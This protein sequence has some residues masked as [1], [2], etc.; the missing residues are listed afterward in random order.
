[1]V[2]RL[3]LVRHAKTQ[4]QET[5]LLDAERRLTLAGLFSI[6]ARFPLS[7]LLLPDDSPHIEVWSSPAL[8][9]RETAEVVA[10][11]LDVPVIE[12]KESLYDGDVDGFLAMVSQAHGTV[13]AVGHNPFME[14]LYGRLSGN[15][16]DMKPGA[17]ASFRFPFAHGGASVADARLEW[18]VQGPDVALWQTI[19]DVENGL[20]AA[21]A[22]IDRCNAA[23]LDNMDDQESLHQYRVSLEIAHALLEFVKPYCKRKP[24]KRAVR[25]IEGLLHRTNHLRDFDSLLELLDSN[26]QEVM[27]L[28]DA[29][30]IER[31]EF[32]EKF[33]SVDTQRIIDRVTGLLREIPWRT[34]VLEKGL[35]AHVLATRLSEKQGE[36]ETQL[37]QV[38]Y[39]S[40]RAVYRVRQKGRALQFVTRE[41]LACLPDDAAAIGMRAEVVQT[42]LGEL[43]DYWNSARFIVG[44]CGPSA[45]NTA[46]RFVVQ[47]DAIVDDLKT[48]RAHGL[49]I[50]DS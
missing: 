12:T 9:A 45:I 8:R 23:L 14:E 18:F 50:S 17:I 28:Q 26:A 6:E 30:M 41:L 40:Q 27:A 47:A 46:A 25:N 2:S 24:L 43:C 31:E 48:G 11:V 13:V 1:M 3:V 22:R 33:R 37:S 44:V 49:S 20:S 15:A 5:G 35:E 29:T 19:V 38:P 32:H 4:E 36:F 7:F 16:Q 10:S 42:R 21:A 39:D 34:S